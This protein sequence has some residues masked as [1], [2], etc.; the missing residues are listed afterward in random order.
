M[1]NIKPKV[2]GFEGCCVK[3]SAIPTYNSNDVLNKH[4]FAVSVITETQIHAIGK[5]F[6][7][8]VVVSLI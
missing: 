8:F 6:V 7:V 5:N 1:Q 2:F 4:Y 3:W